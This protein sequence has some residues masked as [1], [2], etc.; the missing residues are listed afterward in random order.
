MI[1]VSAAD[2]S[3]AAHLAVMLKSL[4]LHLSRTSDVEIYVL[5][6]DISLASRAELQAL[7]AVFQVEMSFIR[8]DDP[9]VNSFR[10]NDELGHISRETYFR[11]ETP[12][13][14]APHLTK[15]IY[16]D[17]DLLVLDDLRAIWELDLAN[18]AVAAVLDSADQW[19]KP[20]LGL[21]EHARY[22]NAGFM[23]MNLEK[24][25]TEQIA[26]RVKGFIQ[27]T[28][29]PLMFMDQDALNYI[30]H[31]NYLELAAKWN[32]ATYLW[33]EIQVEQPSIIHFTGPQKPWN[34]NVPY[35]ELYDYYRLLE[36]SGER[37]GRAAGPSEIR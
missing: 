24:W 6:S 4:L 27:N 33:D 17:C 8:L 36:L 19:R 2:N 9:E 7:A 34:A 18:Y 16:L 1:I 26:A 21:P 11:I 32:Y 3:Y 28:P 29:E 25:R 10:M 13:V 22:F 5:D 14:L 23:V 20:S 37:T 30:L 35:K 12:N 31:D 15:A